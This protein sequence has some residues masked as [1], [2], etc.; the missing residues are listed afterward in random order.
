MKHFYSLKIW[1]GSLSGRL[2]TLNMT[3]ISSPFPMSLRQWD[4]NSGEHHMASLAPFAPVVNSRS[5]ASWLRSFGLEM[6]HEKNPGWL[7]YIVDSTIYPV[8]YGLIV[9][10]P[11]KDPYKPASIMESRRVFFVAQ[12]SWSSSETWKGTFWFLGWFVSGWS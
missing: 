12:V 1:R 8:I 5:A 4:L 3:N 11:Y 2:K 7:R 6:S 10:N 9:I